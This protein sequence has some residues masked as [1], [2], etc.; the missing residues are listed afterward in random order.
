MSISDELVKRASELLP[1]EDHVLLL[2]AAIE[3]ACLQKQL[4]EAREA[5]KRAGVYAGGESF[6]IPEQNRPFTVGNDAGGVTPK[7]RYRQQ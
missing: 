5:L 7:S 3:I 6:N 2:K 1:T 4:D